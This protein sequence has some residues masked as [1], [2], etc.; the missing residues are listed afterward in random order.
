VEAVLAVMLEP[1]L[2][3]VLA[4]VVAVELLLVMI[5]TPVELGQQAKDSMEPMGNRGSLALLFI[6]PQAVEVEQ[7]K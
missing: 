5:Q 1:E 6:T 7:V 4:V 2:M 3:E